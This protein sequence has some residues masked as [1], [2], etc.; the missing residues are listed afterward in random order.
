MTSMMGLASAKM[1][2]VSLSS[3]STNQI[4]T[5]ANSIA[6]SDAELVRAT[7][8]NDL[9]SQTRQTVPNTGFQHEV[10]LGNES[11][12]SKGIKQ[13]TVTILVYKGNESTPRVSLPVT[14]YSTEKEFSGVPIGTVIA[15]AGEKA[16]ATNGTWLEC[17]GQSC[18]A[19]P[20]LTAVLGKTTVPDYRGRFLETDITPGTVKE[21]GLPNSSSAKS[22]VPD[23]PYFHE[24]VVSNESSYSDTIKQKTAIVKVYKGSETIP[25]AEVKLTRYSVESKP[26]GLPIGTII[27]WASTKNPSDGTWLD[28]NGQ[29]CAGYAELVS[30]LGKSTVPDYRNRFLEGSSTPGTIMEAGL[31]NITGTFQGSSGF[32]HSFSNG[33][34]TSTR[35]DYDDSAYLGNGKWR[36]PIFS[37]NASNSNPIYG[38]STTVQP[39]AVTV[40]WLIK[41]A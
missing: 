25:R 37:F 40:R 30:I 36:H 11:D 16:P 15:W 14:R 2:Q 20:A 4:A 28:C 41:A 27:A 21:A 12:Y 6:N 31:P 38:K 7:A 24:T 5:S 18:A 19:Y 32:Y 34:F 35:S 3:T 13:R 17:N 29:S 39:P 33:A 10:T 22:A 23:S 9:S 8:Y 26:S 1:S